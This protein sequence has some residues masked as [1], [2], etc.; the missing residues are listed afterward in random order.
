MAD[1]FDEVTDELRQDQL[2]GLWK[3]YN[4]FIFITIIF[5]GLFI[6]AFKF[7]EYRKNKISIE[8]VNLFLNSL[9]DIKNNKLEEAEEKLLKIKTQADAGLTTLSLF[10]LADISKKRED[11]E[12]MQEFYNLIIN[13]EEIDSFHKN[14]AIFYSTKNSNKLS[15]SEKIKRLEPI[16][17]SPNELQTVGAELEVLYLLNDQKKVLAMQKLENLMKQKNLNLNQRN[18]LDIIKEIY[19]DQ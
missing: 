16:L 6:G 3:K 11:E 7:Y 15:A 1:I 9:D 8:N 5:V 13:N 18:R 17:T 2:K 10:A 14:L 12:R 19:K 4:K